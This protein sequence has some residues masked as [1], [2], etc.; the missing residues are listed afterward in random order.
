MKKLLF[1]LAIMGSV[2]VAQ[3][4]AAQSAKKAKKAQKEMTKKSGEIKQMDASTAEFI[5][6]TQRAERLT[7]QM[8]KQLTLN[9]EQSIKISAINLETAQKLDALRAERSTNRSFKRD[10]Q[11]VQKNRDSEIKALLNKDQLAKYK[12]MQ[13]NMKALKSGNK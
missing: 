11:T 9:E 12:K 5:P 4:V 10:I 8:T 6:A 1:A 2:F 3:D 7:K 13:A